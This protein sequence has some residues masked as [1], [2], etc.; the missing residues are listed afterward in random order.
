MPLLLIHRP[1]SIPGVAVVD[2]DDQPGIAEALRVLTIQTISSSSSPCSTPR[3]QHASK[4]L[5]PSFSVGF[6]VM[7]SMAIAASTLWGFS[8]TIGSA[9]L[10]G[11]TVVTLSS[12]GRHFGISWKSAQ[13]LRIVAMLVSPEVRPVRG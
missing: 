2:V 10:A 8:E 9:S 6:G 3:H 5:D 7:P 13:T 4:R 12:G 11:V 1:G